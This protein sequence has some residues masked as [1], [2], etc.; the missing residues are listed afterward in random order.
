MTGR[1]S[2]IVW[3][4]KYSVNIEVLDEQH[5]KIIRILGHLFDEMG[6]KRSPEFLGG[7]IRELMQYAEEHF[8]A[9][10]IFLKQYGFPGYDQHKKEHESFEAKVTVFQKDF[11]AGKETLT[12][13]VVNFLTG[14][15]DHH[16][17]MTDQGYVS[18]LNGK[19]VF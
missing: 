13:E 3:D 4:E 14:W 1:M 2:H 19:G 6:K 11:E 10:E 16:F 12:I 7:V 5:K 17:S 15:F 8:A 18:F 9:E